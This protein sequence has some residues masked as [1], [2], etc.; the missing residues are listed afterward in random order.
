MTRTE[1]EV[2]MG[3]PTETLEERDSIWLLTLSPVIWS[4]HLLLSYITAAVYCEKY[5]GGDV[6]FQTVQWLVAGYTALAMTSIV[7][8]GWVGYQ[9]NQARD[10][11]TP[12]AFDSPTDRH[13]FIGFAT[14]LLSLLSGV[15]TLFSA[16]V[17]V[18]VRNCN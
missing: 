14:F 5:A 12:R 6:G 4:A 2:P 8:I 10:D 17:F 11:A 7:V 15:A 13:R 3:V 18:F 1:H 9:R 16:M